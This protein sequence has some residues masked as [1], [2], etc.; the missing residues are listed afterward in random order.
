MLK[1]ES[2][3]DV[4]FKLAETSIEKELI[5]KLFELLKSFYYVLDIYNECN[6]NLKIFNYLYSDSK[7]MSIESIADETYVNE[8]TVRRFK[9]K[10]E[11][12][13]MNL[14]LNDEHYQALNQMLQQHK[15]A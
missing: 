10:T 4:L 6:T 12:I 15:H 2:L 7:I 14:I 3:F 9:A 13:L 11:K 8:R 5:E 1:K